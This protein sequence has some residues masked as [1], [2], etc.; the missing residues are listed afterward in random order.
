[1]ETP[2]SLELATPKTSFAT[3]LAFLGL[4]AIAAGWFM[5]WIAKINVSG[6]AMSRADLHTLEDQARKEGVPADVAGVVKRMLANE[7]VSGRDLAVMGRFWIDLDDQKELD[8]KERRGWTLGLAVL[9]WA[10]WVAAG[11]AAL[12]LLGRLRKPSFPVLTL[13]LTVAIL[14]GGFAGLVWLGS[15]E[16]AKNAV[17]DDPQ[18]LGVGVYAIA[19]GGAAAFVGGVLA[20]RSS[21][22]WKAYLLTIVAVVASIMGAVAYVD[23]K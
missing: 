11:V 19:L 9:T 21:T 23:P 15:S 14:V 5:P 8:A 7:A 3:V 6:V 16:A 4:V 22:W 18:I 12:L 13:V 20:V 10:P 1:M 2:S 17:A